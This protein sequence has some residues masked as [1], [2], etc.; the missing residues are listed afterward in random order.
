MT[1]DEDSPIPEE[2]ARAFYL[3]KCINHYYYMHTDGDW[4]QNRVRIENI[5]KVVELMAGKPVIKRSVAIDGDS[6]R[7]LTERYED[8]LY[9]IER[10][11]GVKF[12]QP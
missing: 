1:L 10:I 5:E 12:I 8:D 11:P 4:P 7:G 3:A 9:D 6:I 2:I